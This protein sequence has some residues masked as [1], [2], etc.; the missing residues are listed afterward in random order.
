MKKPDGKDRECEVC[1]DAVSRPIEDSPNYRGN[2]S[3]LIRYRTGFGESGKEVN[4]A[5]DVGKT[6]HRAAITWFPRNDVRSLDA[7]LLTHGHADAVLGLDDVRS[8]QEFPKGELLRAHND[9]P[10]YLD[11][12]TM[13]AVQQMFPYLTQ[14]QVAPSAD[15]KE[16]FVPRKVAQIDW[17]IIRP[18]VPFTVCGLEVTPVPV[19][20]G[21]DYEALGFVFGSTERVVYLSDVSK[22]PTETMD[23][24]QSKPIDIL[25]ID[26]LFKTGSYNTH[27]SKDESLETARLLKPKQTMFTG[28]S[29]QWE[30]RKDNA[31]LS[32]LQTTEGLSVQLLRDGQVIPARL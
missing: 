30:Y 31:E 32:R 27:M 1:R 21:D 26:A 10:V 11:E 9:I 3:L 28:L 2:P 14:K 19:L 16:L 17:Q 15:S 29:D 13:K 23:F 24:L 6:F 22:I 5:I 20:H 18:F 4:I 8:F 25:I 12:R 7:V